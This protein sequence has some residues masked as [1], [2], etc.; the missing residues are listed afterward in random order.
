MLRGVA[1]A[2]RPGRHDLVLSAGRIASITASEAIDGGFVLPG[3]TDAHV[4][5]DKTFTASRLRRRARSLPDAMELAAA[6][7]ARWGED[8]VR[9]R[10]SLALRRAFD[11]G[12][13]R[14]RSHVDWTSPPVPPAWPVLV[15]LRTAWHAR[16]TL[17]LVAL[18]PLDLLFEDG[19]T[20][21][22]QVARDDGVLG[23][24]IYGN[25]ELNTKVARLFDLAERY[26]LSLDLH[27]DEC[28][29]PEARGVDA[30]VHEAAARGYGARVVCGHCCALSVRPEAE[31]RGVLDRAARAGVTL[32][33]L[34]ETNAFLQDGATGRTPRRRG[35][36]PLHEAREAGVPVLLA[37]DNC[38]DAF[39]PWGDYD[40]WD[41][42]RSA[43]PWAH[44]EPAAWLDA[45]TD[46]PAAL[47]GA[48]SGLVEGAAADF[49]LFEADDLDDALSRARSPRQV[50]RNGAI[51]SPDPVPET[52]W[53]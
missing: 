39:H 7:E 35:I 13:V 22:A 48:P 10:A 3:M 49:I 15:E 19:A 11:H 41:V 24:F 37:S 50:W 6:D 16:M 32:C 51:V 28:L 38:R 29:D 31:A 40:L 12:T 43:V 9:H 53:T 46:T 8:D 33:V 25:P 1:I 36:A 14:M 44:L 34:P 21:A 17:Q 30:V 47:F 42:F 2:G 52:A 27:V 26:D 4:H 45:I 23:A 20:I 5:L 18:A